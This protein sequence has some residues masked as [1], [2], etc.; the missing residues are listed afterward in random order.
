MS[1]NDLGW[2]LA[3]PFTVASPLRLNSETSET[4]DGVTIK[5]RPGEGEYN[6]FLFEGLSSVGEARQRFEALRTGVLAAGLYIGGG[7]RVSQD[8][9]ELDANA[10]WSGDRG[11]AM[12][13]PQGRSLSRVTLEFGKVTF[14]TEKVFPR[15]MKGLR[16]GLTAP[17]PKKAMQD[18]KVRL[19]GLLY[20]DSHFEVSPQAQF[21]GLIGVLEV[22]KDT[23]PRS[24]EAGELIDR[25]ITESESVETAEAQSLRG[26]LEHLKS[27]S[28]GQGIRSVVQRHLGE[29]AAR[30]ARDLYAQ[31]SQL[32]HHGKLQPPADIDAVT[33]QTAALVA[34]LL[35]QILSAGQR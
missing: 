28:I 35:A 10:P 31:R 7:V 25:W 12:A 4:F 21:I 27:T 22:L 6:D 20:T 33:R 14:Q 34:R 24:A 5:V 17:Q 15:F 8:L 18:P 16:T 29:A 32:V 26:S 11:Q 13:Y 9:I 30:E 19:A 1:D 3:V 23:E 2:I